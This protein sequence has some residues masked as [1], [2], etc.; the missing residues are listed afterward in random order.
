M[1]VG[2]YKAILICRFFQLI[3]YNES[4]P[5]HLRTGSLWLWADIKN[6]ILWQWNKIGDLNKFKEFMESRKWVFILGCNNSGTT[7]LYYLLGK[8]PEVGTLPTEGHFLTS[9]LKVPMIYD[10]GRLWTEKSEYFRLTEK[11][12][13]VDSIKL[14]HDWMNFVRNKEAPVIIEKSPPNSI[15]SRW[16]QGVFKNSLFIGVTRNGYAVAEGIARRKYVDIIRSAKHWVKVNKMLIEDAKHLSKYMQIKYEDLTS[17][18]KETLVNVIKFIG[19]DFE[20]YP[21]DLKR[22]M[23]IHN[24]DNTRA[25]I[26]N[27]NLKS[28]NRIPS[29]LLREL[30]IE[31]DPLMKEL[32]Y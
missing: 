2:G 20:K 32:G 9:V 28:I 29:N 6:N 16:L 10:V 18:T 4:L 31:I 3:K 1:V 25:Q 17:Q 12:T 11:D 30:S 19:L 5:R 24:I 21:F 26:C 7:L 14:I 23:P 8:H 15:R 22:K 13:Y 27:Y